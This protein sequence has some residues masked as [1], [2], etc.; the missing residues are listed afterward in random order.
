MKLLKYGFTIEDIE[1]IGFKT[2]PTQ[3]A[4]KIIVPV[5]EKQNGHLT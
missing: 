5:C 3:E 1:S 4:Q 2:I